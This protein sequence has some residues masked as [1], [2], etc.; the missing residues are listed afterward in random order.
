M[1]NGWKRATSHGLMRHV[2]LGVGCQENKIDEII[3]TDDE[4]V[5]LKL[6]KRV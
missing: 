6:N 1:E 3:F 2:S 4:F 5:S